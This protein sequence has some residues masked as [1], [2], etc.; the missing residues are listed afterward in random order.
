M[1]T[2]HGQPDGAAV[3]T[4][5][6]GGIGRAIAEVLIERGVTRLALLDLDAAALEA[7]AADLTGAEVLTAVV[8]VSDR[9]QLAEAFAA[10]VD[11]FGRVELMFNNAAI[12]TPPPAYPAADLDAVDRVLDVNV[13]GVVHGTQLAFDHMSANGGGSIVNTASGAGKVP[14][15]ND[16]LYSATKAAVVM[17]TKASAPS[18]GVAGVR[19]NAVC[20]SL[21]D[22]PML[23][24]SVAGLPEVVSAVASMPKLSPRAVAEALV[25]LG[26]DEMVT[27]ETPSLL[28]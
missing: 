3:I 25:D 19:I 1:A 27:G 11:R 22:T 20:P 28:P 24:R 2:R 12:Q 5:A 26:L 14:M 7:A 18:F 9:V 8:D 21:V 17:L 13:R 4:G 15:P 23:Y 10:A 16:P 6:A